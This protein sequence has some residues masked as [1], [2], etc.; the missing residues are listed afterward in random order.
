MQVRTG[1]QSRRVA[2]RRDRQRRSPDPAPVRYANER[3]SEDESRHARMAMMVLGLVFVG[4]C[5]T[6]VVLAA[7]AI[8]G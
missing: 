8:L 3:I 6:Y 2:Q 7:G 1:R 5:V 4:T